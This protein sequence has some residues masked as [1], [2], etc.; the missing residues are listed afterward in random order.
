M[1]NQLQKA[2]NAMCRG[3]VAAII[4]CVS[5]APAA[6]SAA[7]PGWLGQPLSLPDAIRIALVQNSQILKAASDLEAA[8]GVAV[9]TRAVVLPKVRGNANYLHDE[10][11]ESD[12]Q[13][14]PAGIE[15]PENQWNGS[16][17]IVQ[18]IYEGGR[19]R[20]AVRAAR[21][22]KEQAMHEFNAV[23]ADTVLG[24]RTAYYDTLLAEQQVVVREASV[25]LLEQQLAT[26]TRQFDAGAVPRFDVLRGE[27]ELANAR[28]RHIRAKNAYRI[29]KNDLATVLGYTMPAN[30][31]EDVP[32]TLT[33]KLTTEPYEIELPSAVALA[34]S[35]RPELAASQTQL[36][37]QQERVIAARAGYKPTLGIFAG[38]GA[39]NSEFRDDFYRDVSGPMAGVAMTWDIF[40]GQATQGRI[41]EARAR[42]SKAAV[43]IDETIRRIDQEVRTAFSSFVEAR[44]VL[45]S[46]KK[47]LERADEAIRLAGARY[48]AGSG[49]QLDVLNA[50]T[51][52]TEARTTQIEAAR[53]YLVARARLDRAIGLDVTQETANSRTSRREP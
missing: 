50:Q 34:R 9:Q 11:V 36:S 21:L 28:P 47:V 41:T 44:E 19:L 13:R 24:V 17:R 42:E 53:D 27:V 30:V 22:T 43:V 46:Q 4:L 35:R 7:A 26:T 33:T 48:E 3:I 2:E 6:T 45:E 14:N 29:A 38:F 49:T 52:L 40:D 8:H 51:A 5:A 25:K 18:S 37:L 39:R 32:L 16:I 1:L 12:P 15:E 10:A 23:V 20:S 31:S